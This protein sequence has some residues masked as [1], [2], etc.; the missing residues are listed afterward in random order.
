VSGFEFGSKEL[1][2]IRVQ[3]YDTKQY[4]TYIN[5]YQPGYN[6]TLNPVA[7]VA[8]YAALG[9]LSVPVGSS[10]KVTANAQGKWE[11]YLLS[12]TG[13]DRVGL[14][15][16][17][18][19]F[20]QELWDYS[21]GKFGFDVEVFDAQYFDQEPVVETRKIVQAINQELF[22]DDLAIERNRSLVLMFNF[23]LSEFTAPEWL[24]KT[25]LIDVDH[26]IRQLLP[27]QVYRQDNQDFV[28]DYIQEVKPYHTQIREFN[29]TYDGDDLYQGSL[30]DFDL[31]AYYNTSLVI[32]QY[33]SPVLL[34][35]TQSSANSGTNFNAD[36]PAA[37]T[38][39]TQFPY[40]QWYN[41]YLLTVEGVVILDAGTGYT[42]APTI[43][44][45]GD[46]I[47]PAEFVA[48]VNSAG[49]VYRIDVVNPGVGYSTTAELT[50]TGGNGSG[51]R[52]ATIMGNGLVR[53]VKTTIKY[54]RYQYSTDI[55]EW[56]SNVIYTD[57]TQVRYADHVWEANGTVQTVT[58][59]PADW[60]RVNA[61][62][63]SGV[64]RT[65]GLYTPTANEPGLDLPLLIDGID[66]PGVQVYAPGYDAYPGF[67]TAAY[68]TT[69]YDNLAYGPEGRPTYDQSI[70]DAIY[71]SNYLDPY[72]GVLPAPAYNGNPPNQAT[73]VVVDGGEYIDTYSSHAPEELIPGSEFDTLDL[74]VY[75]NPGADWA[76][77]GHGFRE[78]VKMFTINSVGETYSFNG[79]LPT[80]AVILVSN[81]TLGLELTNNI[82]YVID[83]ANLSITLT[84]PTVG[85][86]IVINAYELGGGN[87]VY[88]N[89]YNGDE[90]GN[91][92][93]IPTQYSLISEMIVFVNG[94]QTTDFVYSSYSLTQTVIDFNNIYT[95]DDYVMVTAIGPTVVGSQ[96]IDYS[97]STPVVQDII[98]DGN[99][100]YTLTNSLE[101]TNPDNLIVMVNGLR[102]RT[103]AGVEYFADGSTEY[104]LPE[105]LGFSQEL[106]SPTE[107]RVY[108][109]QELQILGVDYTVDAY[110]PL[111][112]RSVIFA[113][114]PTVG[115][116]ILIYV[117][118]NVQ[119][120]VN[121]DQ[122]VFNPFGGLV[123]IAGDKISVVTWNDTRQQNIL[124]QVYVGPVQGSTLVSEGYDATD[125]DPATVNDTP[126]S[127][128]YAV[129]VGVTLN[130][131]F[132]NQ[133]VTDP[134]RLW[135]T[136]NG[137]RLFVNKD[138]TVV[139]NEIILANY[140]L[141]A[142]DIVM[143]TEF[144]NSVTPEA[145]AFR[146]FQDMRGVQATYRITPATTTYL[147]QSLSTD[148][149]IIYVYDA[150][151]LSQPNLNDNILGVIT[152]N[153]ER[154][155][156]RYRDTM[157]N[158]VSGLRRGTAG[159]GVDSHIVDTPVYDMGRGNLL[160]TRY[161]DHLVSSSTLANGSQTEFVADNIVLSQLDS[162]EM[163]DAVEVYVG[164]TLQTSG[165]I[166]TSANPVTV[167]FTTAPDNGVE[168]TITVRQGKVWYEQ[169][170]S[171]PSNGVA[172]QDTDTDAAR[173]LRGE[174]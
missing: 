61:S 58:F 53:S 136:L 144:T 70:L 165:Y 173:F 125:Y 152:I 60:T 47:E 92:L 62:T 27:Y 39:W 95:A 66:Y 4:W 91:Q 85:D 63:L 37:S 160:Q 135:V 10:V 7:E 82:D 109:D 30:T 142:A 13:W 118:T 45:T 29:L 155:M 20:N 141:N 143:I 121:G 68:D 104:L 79:L 116:Q 12:D 157:A 6:S 36:T 166:I 134:S 87:Q 168:V 93:V 71:E 138:F 14:E 132:L 170:I 80:P 127:F 15:S 101:Y 122:I 21:A 55:V 120:V 107:V 9:T 40:N 42:T 123:P 164:G 81:E 25:S 97:W 106:I 137:R 153:G 158:T 3:N 90:V 64:N 111:T 11:I 145:M 46:C 129:G 99:L 148:D 151:K 159:T 124:T 128:D 75:T 23:V 77:D 171:T 32:P 156:Y 115:E 35:Y 44:V 22:I 50:F 140:V 83:W 69:P 52:A 26:K 73:A 163:V 31:P 150:S 133:V 110:N 76:R 33:I 88:R 51:A 174:N 18:I 169:G 1:T 161:Q 130:D 59:D 149:D 105:R 72:L 172:L 89:S 57:G 102:A 19:E 38:L 49:Q 98:A 78:E 117:N 113:T 16:G 84:A 74:R 54:D 162:T 139:N 5:W 108:I 103:S 56:E 67:D 167:E 8:N 131:L 86:V 48:F 94:V 146:I 24:V 147:V 119:A 2:L 43:T 114:A 28:L 17:T 126:G 154:I 65:M 112:P 34:P 100:T 96:T 41:N